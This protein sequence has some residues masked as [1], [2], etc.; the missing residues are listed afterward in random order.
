MRYSGVWNFASYAH[1]G[2]SHLAMRSK[3]VRVAANLFR[4]CDDNFESLGTVFEARSCWFLHPNRSRVFK[5]SGVLLMLEVLK[6]LIMLEVLEVLIVFC[7]QIL[8]AT[9]CLFMFQ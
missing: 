4:I 7:R 8:W 9:S 1:A 6:V 2:S 3:T 5:V